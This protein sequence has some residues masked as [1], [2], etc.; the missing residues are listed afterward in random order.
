MNT[1]STQ[2]IP[3]VFPADLMN[4]AVDFDSCRPSLLD[5]ARQFLDSQLERVHQAHDSGCSSR[6]IVNQLTAIFD[7]LTATLFDAVTRDMSDIERAGCALLALGGYGRA[8]MNPRSDLDL[9]F[10]YAPAG[11][12]AAKIIADRV[13]YLLWDLRLDVGSSIR[14][15]EECLEEAHDS[16]VRSALLDARQISG[17]VELFDQYRK[18]VGRYVLSN[19]TQGFIKLKL[20]ER[21]ERKNRYGSSVYL[22]EPNLKEGEGGLRELQEA[23][24]IA[25]V[26]FKADDLKGLL[27]KGVINEKDYQEYQSALDYLWKIRNFLHFKGQRKSDQLTF[28]QQ[29]LL[30]AFFGFKKK[31]RDSAVEQFMQEYYA[32]AIQ[33]EHLATKLIITATQQG[34][35]PP[36]RVFN[37]F[38][39]RN[40]EDGFYI[41]RG[42]LRAKVDQHLIDDPVLMMVAFEMAQ[43]HEVQ[44]CL[45][46]KQ[47]IRENA[48][49]INDELR[50]SKR[51]NHSFMQI[52]RHPK[53]V[54]KILRKMH[55]LQFLHAF[56]PEFKKIYCQ[57][58]FDL[59]HIY[60][61]DI[62]TLFA[63]E[64]MEN[65]WRGDYKEVHPLLTEVASNIEKREL[66]LLAI[67]FHDIGK[68]SGKEHSVRGAEMI[69]TIARR[70]R[71]NREDSKRLEFLVLNHLQMAHISQRR[72]LQDFKLISQFADLMGMSENL[73]M[74][75]L[76]TFADIKAVGPDV[77]SEWKGSLLRELYEKSYDALEKNEFYLEKR[78]E[79]IRNRKRNIRKAL[80]GE[81]SDSRI[82]RAINSLHTR[83]LM[84]YR[85]KEI[86][87]HLRLALSRG[88]KTLAMEIQHNRE[89]EYTELTLATIDSPGLFSQITGVLAAHS[90]NILGAQI[91]TRKT[92]AVLD[93][94]QVNSL[95]GGTVERQQ[96]WQ[97]VEADLCEVLEGRV[98]V[99]DLFQNKWQEPDYLKTANHQRTPQRNKVEIDN[100]VSDRYTVIDIFATDKVGLLYAITRTLNELGLYIAVSKIST[101]VDQVA[102]IFY[103]CDIFSQKITDPVKLEEIRCS[104]LQQLV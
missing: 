82:T 65:L 66:L 29:Q 47:L 33:V 86:I 15:A 90:I 101:K 83:Y 34:A 100:S 61:V 49:L 93:I 88:K 11:K 50:R 39:R 4:A 52:L 31:R 18:T 84:S 98:F 104:L 57:V 76:L 60:T 37:F 17:S 28:E 8:E 87:P 63:I 12:A 32:H 27:K 99:E 92:G 68:G 1:L 91:H 53:G 54:S 22:L 46:L 41:I 64:E 7:Q 16:T 36:R 3:E 55:H 58:Q 19:D 40:L 48:H 51:I 20:A 73:R 95:I 62:H 77:W 10:F 25:R 35:V 13:L 85:S 38:S 24:W 102:D 14:S 89:A 96:K 23:L 79:K 69:P 59:Y 94:L 21:A 2:S 71:L 45:E 6:T 103:V 67:L 78:S 75:Y 56:I 9:M 44:L 26:K 81:F 42:E 80:Q 43:K 5:G 97:R 74:L 72:D 70:L 30:A